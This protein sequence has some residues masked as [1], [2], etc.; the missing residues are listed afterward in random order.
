MVLTTDFFSDDALLYGTICCDKDTADLRDYLYR[1]EAWQPK[2]K[3]NLILQSARSWALQAREI[4]QS[5]NTYSVEKFLEEVE[6]HP[7]L[8][9]AL[10]NKMRRSLHIEV[11]ISGVNN[12][13]LSKVSK[14][15]R[16]HR[17]YETKA[18]VYL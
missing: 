18:P 11:I 2:W 3:W 5:R 6:S 4:H 16:V 17:T 13:E 8:G 12:A 15:N 9:V 7:Y 1:L 14:R 10:D